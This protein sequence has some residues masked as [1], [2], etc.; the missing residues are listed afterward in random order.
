MRRFQI[1][2]LDLF[3]VTTVTAIVVV[4][5]QPPAP[6]GSGTAISIGEWSDDRH[7][8]DPEHVFFSILARWSV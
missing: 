2:I 3:I 6:V 8:Q 7:H 1:G 4:L 5:W